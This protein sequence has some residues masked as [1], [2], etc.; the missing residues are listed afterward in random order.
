MKTRI[1][2]VALIMAM[3]FSTTVMAQNRERGQQK[4]GQKEMAMKRH[5]Q[6]KKQ[7]ENFFTEEQREKMKE[8]R[9]ASAKE[10][11]PIKNELN[12]L[13]AKQRTLTTADKADLKAINSNIDNMSKLQADIK[14]IMAKH[15]QEVRAMLSDEQLLK[16]D[17]MKQKRGKRKGGADGRPMH[18]TNMHKGSRGA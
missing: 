16:Y 2:G 12:E 7:F 18:R 3:V 10:I 1:L 5:M 4:P 13:R 17:A 8:M 15:D 9:L 14:K 11:K 6:M